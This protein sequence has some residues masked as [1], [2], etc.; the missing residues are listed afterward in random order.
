MQLRAEE[1]ASRSWIGTSARAITLSGSTS[2]RPSPLLGDQFRWRDF[3]MGNDRFSASQER[4]GP[5][6]RATAS[7]PAGKA[8]HLVND[9]SFF[10]LCRGVEV[11]ISQRRATTMKYP[12]TQ[13]TS[14]DMGARLRRRDLPKVPAL[15]GCGGVASQTALGAD[16]VMVGR[17]L[18]RAA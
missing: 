3:P 1:G 16:V 7:G 14:A 4:N 13:G 12:S 11:P 17:H 2:G 10:S 5:A 15:A 6:I 9:K 18:F 8:I